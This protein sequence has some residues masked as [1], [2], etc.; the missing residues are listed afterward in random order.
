MEFIRFIFSSFWVWLGFLLLVGAVSG[1]VVEVIKACK[2][3][4]TVKAY[5]VGS[6]WR[7]EV[8]N[9]SRADVVSASCCG[10]LA[11]DMDAAETEE[12]D[13]A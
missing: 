11:E 7:M 1:C 8:E 10:P 3:N 2:R 4:R 6:R 9:A 5:R 13:E 12:A